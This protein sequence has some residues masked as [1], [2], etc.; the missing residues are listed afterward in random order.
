MPYTD[1]EYA[2]LEQPGGAIAKAIKAL[3]PPV[4]IHLG[5]FKKGRLSCTDE[6]YKEHYRQIALSESAQDRLHARRQ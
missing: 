6:L 1:T 3:N 2:L 5:D 4:L